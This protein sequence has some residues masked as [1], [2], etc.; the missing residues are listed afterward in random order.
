ME[1]LPVE[2]CP[3]IIPSIREI[4]TRVIMPCNNSAISAIMARGIM[5]RNNSV[6]REIIARGIMPRNNSDTYR[7]DHSRAIVLRIPTQLCI[8]LRFQM[9]LR[10]QC[11]CLM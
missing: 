4:I 3:A 10:L 1:L 2:L 6:I 9:V 8:R 11:Q 7:T 5:H